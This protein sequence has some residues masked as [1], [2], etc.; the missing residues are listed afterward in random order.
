M[1]NRNI[2]LA[3][4]LCVTVGILLETKGECIGM[5]SLIAVKD[6]LLMK[7]DVFFPCRC[8]KGILG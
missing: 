8:L 6:L 3:K 2:L 4:L 5:Q 1:R 7:H